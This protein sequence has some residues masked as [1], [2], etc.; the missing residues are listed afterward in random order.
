MKVQDL[1]VGNLVFA[2]L[3]GE[4]PIL[5]ESICSINEDIFN[6]TTGEIP[7]SSLKP[8]PLT[9]ERLLEF[10]FERQENNWKTFNLHFATISWERLAGIALSFENESVY[11]PHIK[12]VHQLQ[13]LFH[14]LTNKEL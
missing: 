6:S 3:Y 13:N 8:I 1:R 10:G 7:L 2:D 5:V 9:E 4:K 12:Y 11:L 14:S